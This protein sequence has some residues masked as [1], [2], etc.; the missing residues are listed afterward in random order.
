MCEKS[1]TPAQ[2]GYDE[3]RQKE[4]FNFALF[5]HNPVPITV[6]DREGLVV[7]SNLARLQSS[8]PLPEIGTPLFSSQDGTSD[9]HESLMACI[10]TGDVCT[11]AERRIGEQCVTVTLAPFP[12]GA[13]A[14]VED[15][16]ERKQVQAQLEV[17][18]K[19]AAL[20]MLVS[21]VAHEVSNP[22][23]VMILSVD[24]LEGN[25]DQLIAIADEFVAAEGDP[26]PGGRPYEELKSDAKEQ[27]EVISRAADRIGGFV[28]ELKDFAKSDD[29]EIRSPIDVS[30]VA[31]DAAQL[32]APVVRKATHR[33]DLQCTDNLPP[34]RGNSQRLEQVVVN[35]ISNAC[36]ALTDPE[37][38]VCLETGRAGDEVFIRVSDEGIG[39]PEANMERIRD[40]F[41]TTRHDSGGTGLG[42]SVSHRIVSRYGGRLDFES[43]PGEGTSATIWL[44]AAT[45]GS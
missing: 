19:L 8:L 7:R 21:G 6:V 10:G 31:R 38:G 18:Q 40:P 1:F 15:V 5:R 34:V 36:Q 26:V 33:F 16:T 13:I 14:I 4:E 29:E 43:S 3:L 23:N 17:A 44:P 35:L 20:G 37:R 12:H 45:E 42:L 41:F 27:V 39:I 25:L 9:I 30:A 22:N 2:S 32:L 28:R 11:L 24:A